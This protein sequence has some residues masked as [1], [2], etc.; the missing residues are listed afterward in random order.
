MKQ[1][2]YFTIP[3]LNAA[4]TLG[5][6][7]ESKGFLNLASLGGFVTNPISWLPRTPAHGERF[8]PYL[9]GFLMHTGLPNPGFKTCLRRYAKRWSRSTLP[10][11]VHLLAQD[12]TRLVEMVER[13]EGLE[14]V[15]GVEIGLPPE[16]DPDSAYAMSEAAVGEL[17][18]IV[19]LPFERSAELA[20][21]VMDAGVS[22]VSLG[23]PRGI[24]MKED[25][26]QISGRLCGPATFPLALEALARIAALGVPVIGA[27][28]VY[29]R[30]DIDAMLGA[31]AIA[32]QLDS[33]LWRGKMPVVADIE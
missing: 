27:G 2:L 33:V 7:P 1:E 21:V 4:G 16:I 24:L 8:I 29:Q 25:G 3:V 13:L 11:Y 6:A 14:G 19:R 28:G 30:R 12:V 17:P 23:L 31:G 22:A 5:F 15:A 26:S 18:V 9:G 32:V 10:V 20:P